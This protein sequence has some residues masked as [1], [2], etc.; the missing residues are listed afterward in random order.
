MIDYSFPLE[1][2]E[3]Y[4]LILVRV[5]CFI[6]AAPFFSMNNTPV[7]IR[8]G[9]SCFVAYVVYI[10]VS[11]HVY[12]QYDTLFQYAAII[13]EEATIGLL[14]ALGAQFCMMIVTF[15][16][17]FIDIEI[18]FSM[19]TQLDPTTKQNTTLTGLLYQYTFTLIFII[20][21]MY[22]YLLAALADTFRLIPIGQA[23]FIINDIYDALLDFLADYMIIGFRI[24]LPVFCCMLLLNGILGIMAKVSPQMNM[25]AVGLQL[26]I[27]VGLGVIFLTVGL[28][29]DAA[30]FIFENM[31]QVM[32]IFVRAMGGEA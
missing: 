8:I 16:G 9:L 6:F 5:S 25:F 18:G 13:I 4:L 10:A 11:P 17:H 27:L 15:A 14:I 23:Q 28:L 12:P 26:K 3:Y 19:A 7:R 30:N 20:T 22:Q 2:L 29:P 31:K 32:T 24:A 21:G 1:E